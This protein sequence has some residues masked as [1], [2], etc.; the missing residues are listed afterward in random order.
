MKLLMISMLIATSTGAHS[1]DKAAGIQAKGAWIR[2]LPV[3]VPSAGYVI[4]TNVGS[5]PRT[6]VGAT[7]TDFAEVSIHQTREEAGMSQMRPVKTI[8]LLPGT[9]LRF[10][11]GG[12]HL[13]LMGARHPLRLGEQVTLTFRFSD[14]STLDIPFVVRSSAAP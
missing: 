14:E 9:E 12:Y 11:E 6:L 7:G 13:M 5:V 10:T 1:S 2:W 3:D 4:L 8:A